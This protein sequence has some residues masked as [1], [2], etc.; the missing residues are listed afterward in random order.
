VV[1]EVLDRVLR[2][3]AL[4]SRVLDVAPAGRGSMGQVWRLVTER[5]AWSVKLLHEPPDPVL[6]QNEMAL[7]TRAN[8]VSRP[9]SLLTAGGKPVLVARGTHVRV[10]Q[11]VEGEHPARLG[12]A[13]VQV[14]AL[15]ARLHQVRAPYLDDVDVWYDELPS[16]EKW[17]DL[18]ARYGGSPCR[19]ILRGALRAFAALGPVRRTPPAELIACHRDVKPANILVRAGSTVL[20][21]WENAGPASPSRE[22]TSV[23]MHWSRGW[24]PDADIGVARALYGSYLSH[25]GGGRVSHLE[26]FGM[27]LA[28]AANHLYV[29][30]LAELPDPDR[31]LLQRLASLV[32]RPG[33][34]DGFLS[35]LV[36]LTRPPAPLS[37]PGDRRS[38]ACGSTS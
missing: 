28:E 16:D 33:V 34:L 38:R 20:I 2:E 9:V 26:D 17:A 13:A 5:G 37:A 24:A 23:L 25:G 10:A 22:L 4:G 29:V 21:D 8:A 12:D 31:D 3:F 27:Y 11:W 6:L 32:P 36:D 15:L 19:D 30:A 14:G 7:L 1:S 18:L 35:E